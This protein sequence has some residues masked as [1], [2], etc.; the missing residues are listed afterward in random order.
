MT[1]DLVL[2]L[3]PSAVPVPW[4]NPAR[5]HPE[6]QVTPPPD[7]PLGWGNTPHN[8]APLMSLSPTSS[9]SPIS[10]LP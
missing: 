10:Q 6:V 9:P 3:F 1:P 2:L 4:T 8:T 5:V 7:S